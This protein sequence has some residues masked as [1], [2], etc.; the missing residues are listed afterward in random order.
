L[1]GTEEGAASISDHGIDLW[2][3]I[4]LKKLIRGATSSLKRSN[5]EFVRVKLDRRIVC[6]KVLNN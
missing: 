4:I 6:G 1:S 2:N 5:I 3:S